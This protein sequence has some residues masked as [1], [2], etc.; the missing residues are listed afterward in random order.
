MRYVVLSRLTDEGAETL[1]EKPERV[2]EVN[3]ELEKM[4]VKVIEQYAVFGEYDFVNII[5]ADDPAVVMKAMVE[6]ASRGT[7]RTV[8]MPAIPV[9]EFLEKLKS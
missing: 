3:Q 1:K 7:I 9:D 2:K 4:G 6:L 8:T 5:E